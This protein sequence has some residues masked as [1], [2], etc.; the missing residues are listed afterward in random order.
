[1]TDMKG[2]VAECLALPFRNARFCYVGYVILNFTEI[3][4]ASLFCHVL[5]VL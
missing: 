2:D 4:C 5:A 3:F 1:M